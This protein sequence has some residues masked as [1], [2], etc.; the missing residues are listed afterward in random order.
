MAR[1]WQGLVAITLLSIS[2]AAS[3]TACGLTL[4]PQS[5]TVT[6][7]ATSGNLSHTTTFKVTVE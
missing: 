6:L 4:T 3:L 5:S 7:K 2:L 1:R